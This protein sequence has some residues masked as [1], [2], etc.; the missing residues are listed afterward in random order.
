MEHRNLINLPVVGKVQH[1]E[2]LNN[3]VVDYGYFIV[4]SDDEKMKPYLQKFDEQFKGK[5]SIEIEIFDE[6]PFTTK[7]A[8]YNQ[9]GEA[10]HCSE[11]SDVAVMKVK[12]G[13][14]KIKCNPF[15]CQYRVR[16]DQGKRACNRIAWLRFLLPSIT[17][18]CVFLMR[19]T[20]QESIEN[21][22]AVFAMQRMQRNSVKGTYTIYLK[23]KDQSNCFAQSFN[24]YIL[25]ILKKEDFNSSQ[26]ISEIPQKDQELST[27]NDKNVNNNV[28]KQEE[29]KQEKPTVTTSAV[30][31]APNR[32]TENKTTQTTHVKNESIDTKTVTNTNNDVMVADKNTKKE[33]VKETAPKETS[34]TTTKKATTKT[35][36]KKTEEPKAKKDVTNTDKAEKQTSEDTGELS[37]DNVY[38]LENTY[39]EEIKTKTG[40]LKNYLIGRFFDKDDKHFNV[41]I[42][43]NDETR[44]EKLNLGAVV[45]LD[46]QDFAGRQCAMKIKI[47]DEE[48]KIAA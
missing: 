10:C 21:L 12:N 38:V 19:I 5:N 48:Q 42:N 41:L 2:R 20:G 26:P 3:K 37:W 17:T 45:K 22:D 9:G 28:V 30:T 25:N 27:Q 23:K 47:F 46:I 11:D 43:P 33:T 29:I 14:Q 44:V 16:N 31:N 8:R 32:V 13:W 7:Y 24:N 4:K 40:Q 36:T 39:R 34:K 35:N 15:E 6:N 1:G 18:N